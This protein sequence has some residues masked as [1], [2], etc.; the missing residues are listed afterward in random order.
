MFHINGIKKFIALVLVLRGTCFASN[1]KVCDLYSLLSL[2]PIVSECVTKQCGCE[3][4]EIRILKSGYIISACK[5][6]L[7]RIQNMF[8]AANC[9][10]IPKWESRYKENMV[11]FKSLGNPELQSLAYLAA[12][13]GL[14]ILYSDSEI[15]VKTSVVVT[16][17]QATSEVVN[18]ID[19]E[20]GSLIFCVLTS[21]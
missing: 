6:D 7:V 10:S 8:S 1:S 20:I 15:M 12:T 2:S 4:G 17:S 11:E 21:R 9:G 3:D 13:R 19:S 5:N 18:F 14:N 16:E